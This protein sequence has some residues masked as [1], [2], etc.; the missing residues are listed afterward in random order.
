M[1][2][3]QRIKELSSALLSID[4]QIMK[5]SEYLSSL[6]KQRTNVEQLLM[7][8]MRRNNLENHQITL[9]DKK[10]RMCNECNYTPLSYKFL[11]EQLN[12]LFPGDNVK[13]KQMVNYIKSKRD[14]TQCKVIKI[15][16]GGGKSFGKKQ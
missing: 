12:T 5:I 15:S 4:E 7:G 14:K 10:I 11:E 9:N 13:V 8:E 1:S 3:Q 2:N 16:V 6:R